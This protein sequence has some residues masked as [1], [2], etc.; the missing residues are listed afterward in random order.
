MQQCRSDCLL[1]I[2]LGL[3]HV[4]SLGSTLR[5]LAGPGEV[6]E[7][8]PLAGEDLGD[9]LIDTFLRKKAVDLDRFQLSHPMGARDG[10]PL[11]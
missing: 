1:S 9:S 5:R 6:V 2:V 4:E 8:L 3:G 11:S 7:Q 10:L